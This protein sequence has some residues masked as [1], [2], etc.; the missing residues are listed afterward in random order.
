MEDLLSTH[1]TELHVDEPQEA[2]AEVHTLT[3]VSMEELC[4]VE[5]PICRICLDSGEEEGNPLISPCR[6]SG[7]MSFVHR[8]CLDTWRVSCF[9][10][11]ALMECT[12]CHTPFRTEYRGP[13]RRSPSQRRGWWSQFA[14]DVLWYLGV[15]FCGL[16]V[17]VITLGFWPELLLGHGGAALAHANPIASHFIVGLGSSFFL[18]GSFIAVRVAT[19]NY[20]SF[21]L[22]CDAWR[23]SGKIDKLTDVAV[24]ILIAIGVIVCLCILLKGIYD[25]ARQGRHEV[26]KSIQGVNAQVRQQVVRDYVVL[27]YQQTDEQLEDSQLCQTLAV[28]KACPPCTLMD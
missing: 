2:P 15:R 14:L 13:P 24:L 26:W 23:P 27:N 4:P 6:C 28:Q 8:K 16:L 12:T 25:I 3:T 11:R 22:I 17:A 10:P 1:A 18:I 20:T 7:T 19:W 21:R 9:Q 5:V